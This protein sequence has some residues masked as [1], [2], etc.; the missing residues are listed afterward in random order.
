MVIPGSDQVATLVDSKRRPP[1]HFFG[2]REASIYHPTNRGS[3][4]GSLPGGRQPIKNAEG[5]GGGGADADS[6]SAKNDAVGLCSGCWCGETRLW[7]R[8]RQDS[9]WRPWRTSSP[10]A[11]RAGCRSRED[12]FADPERHQLRFLVAWND[13]EGKFAVT[14]HDRTA[15]RQLTRREG[16]QPGPEPAPEPEAAAPRPVGRACSRLPGSAARTGS[17]QRCGRRSSAASRGCRRA[18]RGRRRD[19]GPGARAVD[20]GVV[21][22]RR[23]ARQLQELCGQL[24][25]YLGQAADGCGGA[26]V[27]DA[28]PGP[29][30]RGRTASTREF[31]EQAL[32]ARRDETSARL[33]RV[34]A[35]RARRSFPCCLPGEGRV[36]VGSSGYLRDARK[37]RAAAEGLSNPHGAWREG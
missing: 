29:T 37:G 22:A 36:R 30:L 19:L 23:R 9:R 6:S 18:R 13:V 10:T 20:A 35:R 17:W 1:D 33:R 24:E 27:R 12:L 26:A 7:R 15:Q 32:R 8:A 25:R 16:S 14:C 2:C 5:G 34:R 21:G 11:W 31:R 28:L 3:V 4:V